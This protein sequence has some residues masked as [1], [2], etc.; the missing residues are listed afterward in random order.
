MRKPSKAAARFI[1]AKVGGVWTQISGEEV[2]IHSTSG[3]VN[4][5]AENL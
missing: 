2:V 5:L 1:T 3:A 4:I